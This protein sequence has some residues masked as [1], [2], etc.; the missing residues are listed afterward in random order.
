MILNN[1][2][3]IASEVPSQKYKDNWDKIFGSKDKKDEKV[4]FCNYCSSC[5][6]SDDMCDCTCL[7]E[8]GK[9]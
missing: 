4:K 6:G 5:S 8:S 2:T 3:K 9:D 7:Q 1:R